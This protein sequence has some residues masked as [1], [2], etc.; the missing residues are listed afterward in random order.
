MELQSP[1][2]W[3]GIGADIVGLANGA[4]VGLLLGTGI[5]AKG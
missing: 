3:D 4:S 2:L 1:A 5:A